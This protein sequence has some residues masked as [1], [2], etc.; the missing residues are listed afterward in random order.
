MKTLVKSKQEQ[1]NIAVI[2]PVEAPCLPEEIILAA[3]KCADRDRERGTL[4]P[5]DKVLD[6]IAAKRGWK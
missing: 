6:I 3:A 2:P 4:I 1:H 5:H